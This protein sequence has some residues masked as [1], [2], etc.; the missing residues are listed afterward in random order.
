MN[1]K[2]VVEREAGGQAERV[3]WRWG[4]RRC[5]SGE[6]AGC[7][8]SVLAWEGSLCQ[9]GAETHCVAQADHKLSF[10]LPEPF[11][12]LGLQACVTTTGL[13][14]AVLKDEKHP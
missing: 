2:L 1:K 6:E 4:D 5:G 8:D 7:V 13:F 12:V 14:L 10:L 9:A 3:L 11:S